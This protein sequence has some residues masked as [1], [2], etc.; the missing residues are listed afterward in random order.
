[1][2]KL[3]LVYQE[4]VA[5]H[6]FGATH[7]LRKERLTM[8][9]DKLRQDGLMSK[10]DIT[11]ISPD[12]EVTDEDILAVHEKSLLDRIKKLSAEGGWLDGDTPVPPGT[13]PRAKLQAGGFL[14]GAR[15]V[16][17]GKFDRLIQMPS[18]GGHHAM[19]EHGPI[20]FGFCYFNQEGIVIRA[21]QRDGYIK[22][23]M[24]LDCDCHH[25]NGIQDVFY[26]DPSV[27]Y[28]SLHQDPNTLY[29]ALMGYLD[30]TGAGEGKGYNINVP[31]P[32]KTTCPSYLKALRAI[33]PPVAREFAPDILLFIMTADTHFRDPLT[34]MGLDLKCYPEIASLVSQIANE[35]C[36]GK[37]LVLLGG[38]Y[39]LE[40][41][42]RA[43]CAVTARLAEYDEYQVDDPYGAPK[44]EPQE[45]SQQVDSVI[46]EVKKTQAPYWRCFNE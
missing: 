24:V 33:F 17:E 7:P 15:A 22:K 23:A 8:Y 37:M 16:L 25:G 20:T 46:A 36:Q 14:Y 39:D 4:K 19:R 35:V 13:Y 40:V 1:M 38:G 43:S 28:M 26:D 41:S 6:D 9:L 34:D 3:C 31:L 44:P 21:L 5:Q 29:P 30:E 45:L 42:A 32:P 11:V 12:T 18:F 27:L 10:L 2:K